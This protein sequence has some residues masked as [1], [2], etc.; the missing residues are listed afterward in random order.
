MDY[1]EMSSRRISIM[2]AGQA[3][4]GWHSAMHVLLTICI[5]DK[6]DA[7]RVHS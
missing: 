4:S 2:H 6:D 7:S 1:R 5:R 3:R